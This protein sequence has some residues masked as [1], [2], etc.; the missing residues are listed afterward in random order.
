MFRLDSWIYTFCIPIFLI[1]LNP[2]TYHYQEKT[3]FLKKKIFLKYIISLTKNYLVVEIFKKYLIRMVLGK[4][5]KY[6]KTIALQI[7]SEI[8]Y[9]YN[10]LFYE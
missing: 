9:H 8:S 3:I 5:K 2:F 6:I 1:G 7:A 4:K 10:E